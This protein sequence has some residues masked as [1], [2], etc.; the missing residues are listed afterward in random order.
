MQKS[1][2]SLEISIAAE[3]Y[4]TA[5]A[6]LYET[7]MLGCEEREIDRKI[8]INASFKDEETALDAAR[9]LKS[10]INEEI[11]I[12]EVANQDWIA[13]WREGMK[14][15]RLARGWWVSPLWLPPPK[16]ARHWIKIEPKMAFGTG[17]HE[18]T[19]L[20]AAAI[21][22]NKKFL[23]NKQVLDI[24][25]GSG[26]LCLVAAMC[27]A[28][29]AIGVEIDPYCRENLAENRRAN[30]SG[31]KTAFAI[32]SVNAFKHRPLFDL[33]VMNMILTESSP[34]LETVG[35]LLNENGILIWSGILVEEHRKSVELAQRAGFTLVSEQTENEWWCGVFTRN[36]GG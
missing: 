24:G 12:S 21:I 6:G 4:E 14:P 3:K 18:T 7:G 15:A 8:L 26:V 22:A 33:A 29:S 2:Y 35:T 20:A 30:D 1:T 27:G 25:T 13:K 11:K 32:G 9:S 34:L 31:S 23:K 36:N 16:L 19:R 28:A 5:M 17:H 10:I